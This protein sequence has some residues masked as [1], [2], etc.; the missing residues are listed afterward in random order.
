[1]KF[2]R[3]RIKCVVLVL[4]QQNAL[5]TLQISGQSEPL[6]D[7][8]AAEQRSEVPLHHTDDHLPVGAQS[9]HVLP[10]QHA[11]QSQDGLRSASH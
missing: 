11:L 3:S 2:D 8:V 9:H 1:M 4:I 10:A 6:S 7:P 5:I